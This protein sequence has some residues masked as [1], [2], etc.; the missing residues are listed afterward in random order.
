[1]TRN[2]VLND[3]FWTGPMGIPFLKA[4][5]WHEAGKQYPAPDA[6]WIEARQRVFAGRLPVSPAKKKAAAVVATS[7]VTTTAAVQAHSAGSSL[8][9]IFVIIGIGIIAAGVA[10]YFI[11]KRAS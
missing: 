8:T 5:A 11:H 2:T 3:A 9:T 6:D 1:M 10:W 4:Q 7:A